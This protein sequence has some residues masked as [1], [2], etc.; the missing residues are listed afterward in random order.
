MDLPHPTQGL[1]FSKAKFAPFSLTTN[2]NAT[3]TFWSWDRKNSNVSE[4]DILRTCK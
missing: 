1:V 2:A 3:P 4:A